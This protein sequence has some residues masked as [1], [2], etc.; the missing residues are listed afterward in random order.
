M[1]PKTMMLRAGKAGDGNARHRHHDDQHQAAPGERKTRDRRG[2][3]EQLLRE[4]RLQYRGGIQDAA[5]HQHQEGAHGEILVLIEPHL[6]DRSLGSPQLPPNKRAE[7]H[8]KGDGVKLDP[9]GSE[10][11]PLLAL[12]HEDLERSHRDHEQ[13]H[14][15]IVDAPEVLAVGLEIWRIFHQPFAPGTERRC[16]SGC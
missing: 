2:V 12:V 6:H 16:R 11:V 14:S 15:D 10:P 5:G 3:S 13:N 9:V 7:R 1:N 8:Y 4:L